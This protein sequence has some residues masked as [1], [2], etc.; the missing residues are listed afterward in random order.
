[1]EEKSGVR[2]ES[3]FYRKIAPRRR[4]VFKFILNNRTMAKV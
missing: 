4:V 1:L 3:F 2:V